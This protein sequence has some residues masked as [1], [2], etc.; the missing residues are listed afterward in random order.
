MDDALLQIKSKIDGEDIKLADAIKH[1]YL[2]Y[3]INRV[4]S[5][6]QIH[7]NA[8]L[9]FKLGC[10]F[11]KLDLNYRGIDDGKVFSYISSNMPDD[12]SKLLRQLIFARG[13][14]DLT[15][16]GLNLVLFRFGF[17]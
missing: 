10:P 6:S 8:A 3:L 13:R 14:G 17:K 5:G 4:T 11:I 2:G 15:L 12:E 9:F 7:Q 1:A 16:R